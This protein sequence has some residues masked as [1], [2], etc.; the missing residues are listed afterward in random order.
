MHYT[1]YVFLAIIIIIII[2]II[3]N[4]SNINYKAGADWLSLRSMSR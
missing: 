4:A 3:N 1:V 2:I